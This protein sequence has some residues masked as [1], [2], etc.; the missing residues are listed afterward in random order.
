MLN[1]IPSGADVTMRS[2]CKALLTTLALFAAPAAMAQQPSLPEAPVPYSQAAPRKAPARPVSTVTAPVTTSVTTSATASGAAPVAAPP[3]APIRPGARLAPG[4]PIDPADLEAF[5]DGWMT[6][7]MA[8]EHIA[9][10]TVS[11]VQ[12][13]Q[14]LVK[15]GYGFANL[16]PR[17]AV[18]PDRTLFRIGS[19][20]KTFTWILLMNE[21]DAGRVR[22]DA[23]INLYLPERAR[24]PGRMRDVTVR[25]LLDHSPGFEDQA[26][27]HLFENNPRRVRPMELY[28]RQERPGRARAPGVLSSYSNY[29]SAL[30]GAAVTFGKD[31]TFERLAEDE[32][33]IPLGMN[34]T[35]FREPRPERRGLPAAMPARLRADVS[36]G[37]G[38][39]DAG[40]RPTGYEYIGQIA[41]AGAASSTAGDMARYMLALLG[42]GASNGV[43]IYGPRA[44]T[45]FR[46]PL[47]RTPDGINGWAHGFMVYRLPGD[48]AGYGHGGATIAFHSN[49]VVAPALGLGV[50]VSTNSE[51]GGKLAAALPAA[52][53]DR[54]F[55]TPQTFPRPG[56]RELAEA[57]RMF[58]GAYLS[59]RR[60][61]GGLEGFIGLF[62]GAVDVTV[63]SGGRLLTGGMTESRAWVPEGPLG[64]GRFVAADGDARLAF[65]LV[66][67]RAV[68]FQD[69]MNAATL[70]RAG[71][72][73]RLST[74]GLAAGLTGFA[75]IASLIGLAWRN[76][77]EVRQNQIQARAGIVQMLQAGLW[78][79]ALLLFAAWASGTS[80]LG[81][82]MYRWPGALLIT[83]SAC[84]LV[85]AVLTLITIAALPAVWQGGRRVDSWGAGRKALFTITVLIYTG[86]SVLLAMNGAL[87]PWSR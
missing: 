41:P 56:S 57:A 45:A 9:G 13:G 65:R 53:V 72:T 52:V 35:T 42:G 2:L 25:H 28:L 30:A 59:T 22:L 29:G 32:I 14:I 15:K 87:E 58:E 54:Y 18:D 63:T 8:R 10:A 12:N 74:L 47:Q 51:Q 76:R 83:A 62:S 27:G 82:V 23:P 86:F 7:A 49:M 75:A 6:D 5:L 44:A 81:A 73:E 36:E 3:A 61:S 64:Q 20:S 48:F 11:V 17:R 38:W 1:T 78:I 55:A 70:L 66:D 24:L 4:Q 69:R 46:T 85:A 39:R 26:L 67:G 21:V 19:I 34:H 60:A 33:F 50:F 43:T 80:D 31:R 77:R 71:F 16:S 40:F 68:S 37:F 79:A 84:A